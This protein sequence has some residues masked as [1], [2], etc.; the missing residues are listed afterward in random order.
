VADTKSKSKHQTVVSFFKPKQIAFVR[1]TTR[2]HLAANFGNELKLA[3]EYSGDAFY[4]DIALTESKTQRNVSGKPLFGD[5]KDDTAER[6][7]QQYNL[8]CG[9]REKEIGIFREYEKEERVSR[10][11]AG[12][13]VINRRDDIDSIDV[14]E[15][16]GF[17]PSWTFPEMK[18][19]FMDEKGQVVPVSR[20]TMQQR[21][22]SRTTGASSSGQSSAP[23]NIMPFNEDDFSDDE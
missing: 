1:L 8:S 2:L 11:T 10:V 22:R 6:S 19:A 23:S 20:G 9:F 15:T 14:L 12:E 7:T 21:I 18:G 16:N 3:Y 17:F 13:T 5:K 4:S